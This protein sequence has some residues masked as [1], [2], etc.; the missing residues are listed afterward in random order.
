MLVIP[1]RNAYQYEIKHITTLTG[2]IGRNILL[3]N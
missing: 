3:T 2:F 1:Y